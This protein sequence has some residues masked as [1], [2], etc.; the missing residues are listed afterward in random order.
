[1]SQ[2]IDKLTPV[3]TTQ[4]N[5]LKKNNYKNNRKN[6]KVS[7]VSILALHIGQRLK[8]RRIILG[9]T[10]TVLANHLGVSFQQIQKYERGANQLNTERLFE[11]SYIMG[12]E[13]SYFFE[14]LDHA[15]NSNK[16]EISSEAS[17][18]SAEKNQPLINLQLIEFAHKLQNIDNPNVRKA[19]IKLLQTFSGK[20]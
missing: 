13:V 9:M 6:K 14:D 15:K 11:L 12:V 16:E 3:N 2:T 8:E 7:G 18:R 10:Q 1:M 20:T 17:Q 4:S 19:I 5:D